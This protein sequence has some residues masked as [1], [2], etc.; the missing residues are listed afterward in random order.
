MT[1]ISENQIQAAYAT[2]DQYP[3]DGLYP[4]VANY[5]RDTVLKYRA[6]LQQIEG[7]ARWGHQYREIASEALRMDTSLDYEG[8]G[9]DNNGELI[10]DYEPAN[11]PDLKQTEEGWGVKDDNS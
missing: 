10:T 4:E 8:L 3:Q 1:E 2:M 6:A 11:D 9:F 7:Y 5:M